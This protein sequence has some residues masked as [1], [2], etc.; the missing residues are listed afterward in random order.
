MLAEF[1]SRAAGAG[2]TRGFLDA[3]RA[4]EP[5]ALIAEV[6][7][8][9]PARGQTWPS[10]NPAVLARTYEAAG[11]AALSVLT[12][13]PHF[14]GSEDDLVV[15]RAS[16][17]LPVL[18][19]D[20]LVCEA[21]V[22]ESRAM[23]AD[24]VLL[25]VR[26]LDDGELRALRELAESLGMDALVETHDRDEVGRALDSGATIVGVNNR[27]LATFSTTL[28]PSKE[29]LPLLRGRAFTVSE[30]ALDSVE[31]VRTVH[32]YGAEAVLIGTAF[33]QSD[34]PAAKVREVMGR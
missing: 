2:P 6:K 29:L 3:L 21:D 19:K 25:I 14:G 15:A 22:W 26:G 10:V 32:A 5:P 30:S 11:A 33:C 20:F 1:R 31:A 13:G 27:D 7:R 28:E 12:D 9:S 23:G 4:G 16:C 34:D 24:A 18:R 17:S 8:S